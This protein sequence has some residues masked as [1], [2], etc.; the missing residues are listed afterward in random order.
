[1]QCEIA[2][3]QQATLRAGRLKDEDKSNNEMISILKR[4]NVGKALDIARTAETCME[5]MVFLMNTILLGT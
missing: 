4:N 2:I 1:M 5:E 3:A